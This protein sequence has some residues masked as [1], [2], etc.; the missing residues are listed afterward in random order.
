MYTISEKLWE[1]SVIVENKRV[2]NC[3][4]PGHIFQE[5]YSCYA[6]IYCFFSELSVIIQSDI[7]I[8]VK[9][10]NNTVYIEHI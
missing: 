10:V 7:M 6:L 1:S 2:L 3:G 8:M 5:K 4:K 9:P